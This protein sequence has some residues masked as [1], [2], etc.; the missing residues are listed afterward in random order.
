VADGRLK[1]V[2]FSGMHAD[3][4]GGYPDESLSFVSLLWMIDELEGAVRLV[5]DLQRRIATMANAHIGLGRLARSGLSAAGGAGAI[6][7][8]HARPR[9]R[10][11]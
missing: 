9:D 11:C 3:V 6:D 10:R 2:W 8:R 7:P 5:P 4:G 1:Q